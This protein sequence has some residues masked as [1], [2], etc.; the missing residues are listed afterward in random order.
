VELP[1]GQT[2]LCDAG[3][4]GAPVRAAKN[5]SGVLWSRGITHLDAIVISHPDIDHYNGL[6][7]LL[8]RFSVGVV[9]V[10]PVM[11]EDE[12]PTLKALRASL[13]NRKTPCRELRAGQSLPGGANCR[14]EV[15]HPPRR[16]IVGTHNANS[17]VL[18]IDYIGRRILLPGDLEALG[19]TKLL[20]EDPLPCTVLLAP[21]HGSRQSNSPAL[22]A[23]CRPEW[24]V[25]S[26]D[27]RWS[28]PET[29]ATY[30]AVGGQILHTHLD[31]AITVTFDEKET[32][33]ERFLKPK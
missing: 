16:G 14:I 5:I 27:G 4:M 21:H 7:E 3:Q 12:T 6:P 1:S 26:G 25:L 19:M 29:A 30:R 13:D 18:S 8:K 2:L 17:V 22:A 23:W 28:T 20:A 33:V 10:S 24:I 31:G 15:L 32:K 9:Y 11:F